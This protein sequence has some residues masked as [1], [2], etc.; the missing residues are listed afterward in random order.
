MVQA[1]ALYE[2]AGFRAIPAYYD[3][4]IAGTIFLGRSLERARESREASCRIGP[5]K[6]CGGAVI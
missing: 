3:T 2:G 1:I 6:L 4:P 5:G